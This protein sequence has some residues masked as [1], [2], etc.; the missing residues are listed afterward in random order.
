MPATWPFFLVSFGAKN[1][2]SGEKFVQEKNENPNSPGE[3][4]LSFSKIY[5][6]SPICIFYGLLA[7]PLSLGE[8]VQGLLDPPTIA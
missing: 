2:P 1:L 5:T 8:V 3:D 6:N 4:K 7:Y